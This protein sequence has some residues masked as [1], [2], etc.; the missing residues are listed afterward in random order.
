[1]PDDSIGFDQA[2]DGVIGALLNDRNAAGHWEGELSSSALST[3]TAVFALSAYEQ[4]VAGAI[5]S[6]RRAEFQALVKRGIDWLCHN[7][8]T[9]GGWGDTILSIS[10]I[11]TTALCWAA[12]S[13]GGES[14][15]SAV[16]DA[17]QWLMRAAGSLAPAKLAA[18]IKAR[19]GKDR[20][21]SV[22][23]LTMC[24]LAGRLGPGRAAWRFVP[25]LP[26]ELAACPYQWFQWLRLPVVSYALPA[27]IAIGHVRHAR[28]PTWNWPARAVRTMTKARTLRV[29]RQIQPFGGGFLEATPLTSFVVM[30]LVGAGQCDHA[31]AIQGIDFL[32]RSIRH[33]G[34]WPI[35]TNLSTWVTTLSINALAP[36]PAFDRVLNH[37]D[38][39]KLRDWL[40]GQQYRVEHPYT[41][42]A[43]GAWAWTDLPGGVPDADDTAGALLALWNLGFRDARVLDS[44]NAAVNWLLNL[45]NR[46]G[47]IPTFCRG[48]GA[49][50]FDR[51]G[52]DLTAHALHALAAWKLSL[53]IEARAKIDNAVK[54]GLA[55]LREQQR[56]DGAWTP[57]WFGNQFAPGD[58]NATYGTSRVLTALCAID[59]SPSEDV[60]AMILRGAGWLIESQ[61]ADGGWGGGIDTPSSIEETSLASQ[62]LTICRKS[63]LDAE[64]Q[65]ASAV[66]VGRGLRWIAAKTDRGR[67]FPASPIGFYFAKLWYFERLY[68]AIY[69][70]AALTCSAAV[71]AHELQIL[72]TPTE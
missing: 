21:F 23:I 57:L 38:R 46:D 65:K 30:S 67:R 35:D 1:M 47:G 28:R 32:I 72:K 7:Q 17:E 29:L 68:P 18:A 62:A 61:N 19:Y 53:P 13:A 25:Q 55:Y 16:G 2:L 3:A 39:L 20:T 43:P 26:F 70:C 59:P 41:H 63:Y 64:R 56:P 6:A 31:V 9:D 33:D 37:D 15:S 52:S 4:T 40:L 54:S 14:V 11:S 36:H 10:N 58:E 34:S 45:Q 48:W 8:N 60:K 71:D 12:L 66:V 44:V 22:P 51:S 27:L 50:P 49:L 42:A 69:A 24:A 5:D